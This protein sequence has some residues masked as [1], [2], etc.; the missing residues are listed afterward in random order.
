MTASP[1]ADLSPLFMA[2]GAH[3][4]VES[5]KD[6]ERYIEIDEHFFPAYRKTVVTPEE[7]VVRIDVPFTRPVSHTVPRVP[8]CLFR[9]FLTFQS[10]YFFGYK[11]A[12]RRDDDIAI[13]N[14]GMYVQLEPSTKK[15]A[16]IRLSFGGVGPTT[17]MALKTMQLLKGRL[18]DED[19]L[20]TGLRWALDLTK[21]A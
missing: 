18:W 20:N 12:Q 16:D 5:A 21:T 4:L 14:A 13:V 1:I 15:I 17:L 9:A 8:Q 7:V 11:Q 19:T 2:A 3:I 6:G 10:Q